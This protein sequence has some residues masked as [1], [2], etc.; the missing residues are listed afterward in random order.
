MLYLQASLVRA[1]KR[2]P[3]IG[4]S[5]G[6]IA[7]GAKRFENDGGSVKPFISGKAGGSAGGRGSG[8]RFA[9]SGSPAGDIAYEPWPL[10]W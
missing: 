1:A 2:H 6:G 10:G 4:G 7:G 8:K 9:D 3:D 5:A